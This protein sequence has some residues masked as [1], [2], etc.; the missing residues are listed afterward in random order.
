MAIFP[1]RQLHTEGILRDPEPYSLDL[2]A[3]SAGNDVR[4]HANYAERAP[5]FKTLFAGLPITNPAL[6]AAVHTSLGADWVLI[7][8]PGEKL[9]QYTNGTTTN[10]TPVSG[11][12]DFRAPQAFTFTQLGDVVYINRPSQQPFYYGPSSGTFAPLPGWNSAWTARSLRA[13]GDYLIALNVTKGG[14]T[15]PNMVKG[16]DLTLF[17]QP[18]GSWDQTNTTTS[19]TENELEQLTTG[20]VD[21]LPMRNSFIIYS[22]N[23]AV[24]MEQ[25]D[26]TEI[27]QFAYLGIDGGM[28]APNCGV[29]RDGVHYV[30]GTS[31]IYMHDGTNRTSIID[32][33][34]R[35]YVFD[36]LIR[37]QSE[38]CFTA[39]LP[40][41]DWIVFGYPT[42]APDAF[43]QQFEFCNQAYVYD[44]TS[45]TGTFIS[46]PDVCSMS[47]AYN[48]TAP[49]WA[50]ETNTWAAATNTWASLDSDSLGTV[51]C[52]SSSQVDGTSRLLAY[53]YANRGRLSQPT[54]A[55]MNAPM[56]LIRT[57]IDLDQIGSDITT[58]KLVKRIFPLARTFGGVPLTI[59]IGQQLIPAGPVTYAPAVTF[60]PTT[61][62]KVDFVKG[63]RFLAIKVTQASVADFTFSGFDVDL[64]PNGHR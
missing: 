55:T 7:V 42:S 2:N 21:G 16:S 10:I 46:L 45:Q 9:Y 59:Q 31:D 34:N 4:F 61:Q 51:V 23:D 56:S 49:T 5:A 53:D 17:G 6:V 44:L 3:F 22:E 40:S 30:L 11:W 1:V 41:L 52:G 50:T 33:R 64:V 54:E 48:V 25:V 14:V 39:Y 13:F 63:G 20:I 47:V 38:A 35:R 8:G 19:A 18:P 60:D 12:S 58:Y 28:I 32:G 26:T 36:N 43:F 15:I 27:F 57:G 37:G 24:L 29:E 62:Y